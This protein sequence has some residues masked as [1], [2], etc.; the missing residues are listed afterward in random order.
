MRHSRALVSLASALLLVTL[1]AGC[2]SDSPTTSA[3]AGGAKTSDAPSS[4]TTAAAT[5]SGA[6]AISIKD[7]A[8]SPATLKVAVGTKVTV[9]NDDSTT[10]TWSAD[11]M[12]VWDSGDL[13]PGKSH[14]HTFD[15][16]GSFVYH[17]HIHR[18]MTGTVVV[19]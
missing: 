2:G 10:H 3:D 18:S 1:A 5:P 15:K 12:S 4:T 9:T 13:A 14:D 19:S 7:F 11:D 16:A 8:F 17:C 6:T